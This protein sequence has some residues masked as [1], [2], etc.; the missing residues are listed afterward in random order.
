MSSEYFYLQNCAHR[1]LISYING[2]PTN[3]SIEFHWLLWGQSG[4]SELIKGTPKEYI[5]A[6][7]E[8]FGTL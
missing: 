5:S 6:E 7:P 2:I 8:S 1:D 4:L 3:T